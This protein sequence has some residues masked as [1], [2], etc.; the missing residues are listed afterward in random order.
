MLTLLIFSL[1]AGS[2]FSGEGAIVMLPGIPA[3]PWGS[4]S[5]NQLEEMWTYGVE[6]YQVTRS[7]WSGYLLKGPEGT[8]SFLE[9]LGET[10]ETD[11]II[12]DSSLWAR[13][14]QLI[15]NTN[16][17]SESWLISDSLGNAPVFPIRT[18]HWLESGSDTLIISLPVSNSV[19]LWT[20][21]FDGDLSNAAWR[22]IGTEVI[23]SGSGYTQALVTCVVDGSPSDI[24]SLEY[25]ALEEDSYWSEN[26]AHLFSVADS[27]VTRQLGTGLIEQNSLVWIRGTGGELF[28]PWSMIP[29]PSPSAV[30]SSEVEALVGLIPSAPVIPPGVLEVVMPGNAG[31][32]ARAA[33]AAALLERIVA[34]MAL[35]SGV[36]CKAAFTE[37]GGVILCLEGSDWNE[38]AALAEILDELTPIIFTSPERELLHNAAIKA[39]IPPMNQ[40]DTIEL[41]A[42]VTGFLN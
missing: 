28:V 13:S 31:S 6:G 26:W 3:D 22:G 42:R 1:I 23:P 41:L 21:L 24:F 30:A 20:G 35:D 37:T 34:R 39:G 5:E 17:L 16:A 11:I 25:V 7:G 9:E 36:T 38:S 40:H 33:Y 2:S 27:L 19:F 18:S 14:M 12:A 10:L 29:S 15:W 8:G 4:L 32:G